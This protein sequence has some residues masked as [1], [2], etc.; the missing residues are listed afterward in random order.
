M[1][2][3][4]SLKKYSFIYY[5]SNTLLINYNLINLVIEK[6]I[7]KKPN[8]ILF[9]SIYLTFCFMVY[10]IILMFQ[11]IKKNTSLN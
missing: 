8:S 4:S 11:K 6:Q 2:N 10:K 7:C 9:Y 5:K 3:I 1:V